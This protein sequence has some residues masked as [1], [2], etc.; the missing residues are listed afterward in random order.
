ML[1]GKR[2]FKGI[3]IIRSL[4]VKVETNSP[5]PGHGKHI[6][7]RSGHRICISIYGHTVNARPIY[8][9]LTG[10]ITTSRSIK[11]LKEPLFLVRRQPHLLNR[12]AINTVNTGIA[13]GTIVIG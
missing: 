13:A 12:V 2:V 6:R 10:F 5:W 7:I 3:R 4:A 9:D 1:M 11:F 8:D